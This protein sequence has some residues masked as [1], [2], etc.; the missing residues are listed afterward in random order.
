MYIHH[1]N[2]YLCDSATLF[3]KPIKVIGGGKTRQI[4]SFIG[5]SSIKDH[6][7][8]VLIHDA[9]RPFINQK[10]IDECIIKL[11]KFKAVSTVIPVSDTLYCK[12]NEDRIIDIPKRENYIRAQTPQ[13][14]YIETIKKA[15]QLA[16]NDEFY[17]APD[18]CFLIQKYKLA[19][20]GLVAGNVY[21]FKVTYPFDIDFA[22]TILDKYYE[23]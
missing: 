2:R 21:N 22:E 18:D 6:E 19:E 20:I 11:D 8:K 9:V 17:Q 4:S 10:I 1:V 3:T 15:H 7:S 13:G 14:F 12:D 5:V 16:I 23:V